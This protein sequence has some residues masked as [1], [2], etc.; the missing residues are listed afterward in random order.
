MYHLKERLEILCKADR[1]VSETWASYISEI[2]NIFLNKFSVCLFL[3]MFIE[4]EII[5]FTKNYE[6]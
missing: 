1:N 2:Y 6:H 5:I 4:H 3:Y